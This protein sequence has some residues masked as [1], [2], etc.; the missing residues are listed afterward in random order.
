MNETPPDSSDSVQASIPPHRDA[1]DQLRLLVRRHVA[2]C[3]PTPPLSLAELRRH[4]QSVLAEAGFDQGYLSYIT[5]L[6][7]NEVWRDRV[8]GVPFDKRLLLLPQCLRDAANCPAQPDKFGMICQHC[9]RC[10][11]HELLT[12]A[13]QLGYATLVA[14]GTVV[15]TTLIQSNKIEAV[16]GVSCLSALE[17]LFPYMAAA[18]C[19]GIAVPLLRDGC[20]NTSLDTDWVSEAIQL[21]GADRT[22]RL[23]LDDIRRQVDA[24]F[25]PEALAETLGPASGQTEQIAQQ[26]LGGAGKRWRPFLAACVHQAMG[27]QEPGEATD[28]IRNVAVAVECFHKASL[29]HDDIEDGDEHRYGRKAMHAQHGVPVALNVGDLLVGEGYRMLAGADAPPAV[30]ARMVAVAADAHRRLC[31]GQGA[32][33]CWARS[34]GPLTWREVLDIYAAKTAPAFEVSL[35]L[36][37]I[38]AGADDE[39]LQVLDE[40]SKALGTAYQIRD[41]LEDSAGSEGRAIQPSLLTAVA[42]DAKAAPSADLRH[43]A[44]QL[45]TEYRQRAIDCLQLLRSPALKSLLR[46]AVAKI[47]NE[48]ETQERAFELDAGHAPRGG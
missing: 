15:I 46:R 35:K 33:L 1:R 8:S 31:I 12:E 36:A 34:G 39:I 28:A 23:D 14:E 17:Q 45:M 11:I 42:P 29:V 32:E 9:G 16:V 19:P 43:A 22:G 30:R 26:W 13:E 18:A 44:E 6:M 40:Y 47:F 37:A 10:V 2:T 20:L 38:L 7:N 24:W 48:I 41:D 21:T 5:V 4:G 3:R 27:D 25:G